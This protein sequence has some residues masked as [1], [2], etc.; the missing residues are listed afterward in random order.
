MELKGKTILITG[1]TAGIGL[2]AAKQF[3][4]NGAKVIITG[5]NQAKLDEATKLLPGLTA[6]IQSDVANPADAQSLF[7]KVKALGGI[8]I[9]YNNAGIMGSGQNLGLANDKNFAVAESEISVNYLGV[10]R[11]NNVFLD[12]LKSRKE[13][14]IINT[15][16]ALSHVPLNL[17]PTYSASKAAVRF[18]TVALRDHLQL[19][20]SNVRVFELQPPAVAT[21]MTKDMGIRTISPKQLIEALIN[22]IKKNKYTIRVGVATLLYV[23]NRISPKLAYK[24]VNTVKNAE[25]LKSLAA[26]V[27]E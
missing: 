13:A 15:S 4:A 25:V 2:E 3:L 22:G 9:L 16:S 7:D 10:I 14:A 5:R 12:M 26:E 20:N 17:A 8:D 24:I 21:E 6:S 18:Y 11:L 1:G 27:P 19:A 23:I